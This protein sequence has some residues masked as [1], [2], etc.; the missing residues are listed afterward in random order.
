VWWRVAAPK[1]PPTPL[2][3]QEQVEWCSWGNAVGRCVGGTQ[4]LVSEHDPCPPSR[5]LE[6]SKVALQHFQLE[7][8]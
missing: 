7:W 6:V 1:Q 4:L 5:S 2:L 3:L 8:G